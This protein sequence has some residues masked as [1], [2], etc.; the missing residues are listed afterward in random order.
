MGYHLKAS[1]E[2]ASANSA[3]NGFMPLLALLPA[4]AVMA[5]THYIAHFNAAGDT[6]RLQ[7]LL[8]GCR[9][10]LF[11]L[12]LFGSL[13]AV[14]AIKPLSLLFHYSTSL[15][16]VTLACTLLGLWTSLATALCQGLAWFKRLALI[17]FIAMLLRVGFGYVVTLKW[18]TPEM[19]VAA[20]IFALLAYLILWF[21]RKELVPPRPTG[22]SSPWNREF[23]MYL[24]I[25]AAFIVGNYC[26]SQGD[27]MVM[28]LHFGAT[29][30]D[31]YAA[32]ERLAA[33]LPM[34]AGPL[35][36]VLFTHRSVAHT[37]SALR[38]QLKLLAV[39][40]G[41]LIAGA[42][43]LFVLRHFCLMILHK[44]SP[45]AAGMIGRLAA[46]MVFIGLLQAVGTWALASRWIKISLLYGV[47]GMGYWALI[48]VA[49]KTPAALLH[50][51]PVA[52][53]AAFFIVLGCWI[54]AMKRHQPA[55]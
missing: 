52:T 27:L 44:D 9:R 10:F 21:W 28:Q 29:D 55:A 53:S 31:S 4:V 2:Y 46:A 3:I 15:M 36:T 49:G 11:H 39:Y 6:E 41:G 54:A 43:C 40:A 18:P 24:T 34:A 25:S 32:A 12:M 37:S 13:L 5:V 35:L 30:S 47:L 17:T 42:G 16:L 26:F 20:S 51:M 48:L 33:A 23:L 38:E 14:I 8:A 22:A 19:T 7:N 1:G 45:E 50:T